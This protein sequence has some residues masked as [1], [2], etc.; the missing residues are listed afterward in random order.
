MSTREM[1]SPVLRIAAGWSP[2][3]RNALLAAVLMVAASAL[4]AVQGALVKTGLQEMQPLELVFFRGLVCALLVYAYARSRRL[5]LASSRA[6]EQ[7]CLG[8]IGFVTLAL[9]FI[10]IGML[11]LVT[12]TALNYSAPLFI[13]LFLGLRLSR[14]PTAALLW[15]VAGFAGVCLVLQPSFA[16]GSP[17]GVMFGLL[18]GATGAAG[19]LLL[20]RLGRAGEPQRVTAFWFS[21]ALAVLAGI[22]AFGHGLSLHSWDNAA[23]VLAIGLVASFGQLAMIKAYAVS[24]PLIPSTLSY[25][26]VIF[27]SVIGAWLWGDQ[28]GSWEA[29]GIALIVASGVLVSASQASEKPGAAAPA[30]ADEEK[31]K[32]EYRKHTLRSLYAIY[33]LAKEPQKTEYVFMISRAQDAIAE[34]ERSRGAIR[35]PFRSTELEGMWQQRFRA[36]SYDVESL[37]RLPADTLGGAYARHM[38]ANGLR[39]DYY[40][41]VP[42]HHRMN[43]LRLR[44]HQTHDIWHVLTGFGADDFGE[45]GIQGF[46]FGQFTS[47]QAA[48]IGAAFILK[49]VLRGRLADVEKFV[50]N[51]CEG[52]CNGKRAESLLSVK[53]EELWTEKLDT[54]RQRYRIA[55]PNCRAGVLQL[56]SA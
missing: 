6:V 51:F 9:Y 43:F 15:V 12:A 29:L 38:K 22:P 5:S 44:I 28:L 13:A 42:L 45:I 7:I 50:D 32:R 49:S 2:A 53:W 26:V 35:D 4:F 24:N 16:G 34:S 1:L 25:S 23:L 11:P 27:S 17:A 21:A 31:C 46:Y 47:G 10:S 3:V 18:S 33:R 14:K 40:Q 54:V 36:E 52:Y 56:A 39:P 55:I 30:D 8:V 48:L 37:L 19:Y 41:D 20:G